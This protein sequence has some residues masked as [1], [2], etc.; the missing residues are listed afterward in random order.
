M[1]IFTFRVAVMF[2]RIL[3]CLK[4]ISCYRNID[5]KDIIVHF[6]TQVSINWWAIIGDLCTCSNYGTWSVLLRMQLHLFRHRYTN[7][8]FWVRGKIVM[9]WL[10]VRPPTLKFGHMLYDR[11]VGLSVCPS[12]FLSV[13]PPVIDFFYELDLLKKRS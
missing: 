5:M 10:T 13:C 9:S 4:H 8:Q 7:I 11:R 2:I 12:V 1:Y 6:F 3:Y